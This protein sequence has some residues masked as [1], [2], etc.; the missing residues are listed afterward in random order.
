MYQRWQVRL[1]VSRAKGS[2]KR[3]NP[4]RWTFRCQASGRFFQVVARGVPKTRGTESLGPMGGGL[5][6]SQ[7][8]GAR[9]FCFFPPLATRSRGLGPVSLRSM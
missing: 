4:R 3:A 5:G 1:C 9:L 8:G 2:I 7:T 6:A